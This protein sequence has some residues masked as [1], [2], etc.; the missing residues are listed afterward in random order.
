MGEISTS[1]LSEWR[2]LFEEETGFPWMYF[3]FRHS[4]YYMVAIA[5]VVRCLSIDNKEQCKIKEQEDK[6]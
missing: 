3:G 1:Y 2:F 5:T 6:C 4:P